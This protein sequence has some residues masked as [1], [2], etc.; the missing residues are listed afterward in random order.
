MDSFNPED[1]TTVPNLVNT[2]EDRFH[3]CTLTPLNACDRVVDKVFVV[4]SELVEVEEGQFWVAVFL[5]DNRSPPGTWIQYTASVER[6][7]GAWRVI[8]FRRAS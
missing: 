8:S 1:T 3:L 5:S 4:L 7:R 6:R 2:F